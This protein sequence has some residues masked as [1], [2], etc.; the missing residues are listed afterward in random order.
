MKG[1]KGK[2]GISGPHYK[3]LKVSF[4]LLRRETTAT[5]VLDEA[6]AR[7]AFL[8]ALLIVRNHKHICHI[9]FGGHCQS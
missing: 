1:Q 4:T 9:H 6:L 5:R 2:G 8:V 7:A 3:F